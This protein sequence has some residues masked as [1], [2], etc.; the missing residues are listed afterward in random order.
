MELKKTYTIIESH[1]DNISVIELW[2]NGI[3]YIKLED[4]V[5]VEYS[6]AKKQFEFLK[7]KYNGN[8]RLVLVETGRY[9]SISNEAR[10]FSTRSETN[11]YTKASAVIVKSLAHRII[12]NFIINFTRQQAMKM[13]MFDDKQ[14]AINWLLSLEKNISEK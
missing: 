14:K 4:N 3:I 2:D 9:T 8:K 7:S 12:I 11:M 6:D 5:Q 10:E 13:R 1:T